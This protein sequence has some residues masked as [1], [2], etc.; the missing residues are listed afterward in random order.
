MPPFEDIWNRILA[1]E[2]ETFTTIT[3]LPFTYVVTGDALYP[4]RTDYRLSRS[5]V[6]KAYGLVPLPGP[7]VINR[8]VRGPA[9]IWAILH[10][11]RVSQGAWYRPA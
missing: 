2:G 4:S 10:D 9:Y 5:D 11:S 6:E 8:V 1:L 3:G 7:G